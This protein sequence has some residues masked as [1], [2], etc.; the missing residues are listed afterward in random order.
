MTDAVT[1]KVPV[2][3][4]FDP[5]CPWAWMTSRW[6]LE[7]ADVRPI[8]PRWRLMSLTV[9]NED[10]DIPED[11]RRMLVGA[12]GPVR[13]VAAAAAKYGEEVLGRLYTE[14][15]V[16]FHNQGRVK[17]REAIPATLAEALEAAG[18][19]PGLVSA[20]DST[21]HDE[22][23]RAS[24]AEGIGLVGQEV[25]TPVIAVDG[26]E[27]KI[28]FFGPVVSPAPRGEAAGRLWDGVLLVAGT[29]GFFEIK[30]S[31]TRGPI[32]D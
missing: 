13:V 12:M 26:P 22:Y 14:I 3:L 28:A 18:L 5:S 27:G 31:R 8:E 32:F 10:K 15:G 1:P 17:D 25:G 29:D 11:Y 20:I 6:L 2:D 7:V 16:R 9:L 21:E 4:W 19:D 24:H 30:R 23:I